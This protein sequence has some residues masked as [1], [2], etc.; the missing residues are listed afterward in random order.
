MR[1]CPDWLAEALWHIDCDACCVLSRW[2]V[3]TGSELVAQHASSAACVLLALLQTQAES[4][5]GLAE[6]PGLK[7]RVSS[8]QQQLEHAH[9]D[10]AA[11]QQAAAAAEQQLQDARV[12]LEQANKVCMWLGHCV[13]AGERRERQAYAMCVSAACVA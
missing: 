9:E 4:R 7:A 3:P 6:L 5:A 1:G 12:R 11:A 8:L 10:A 13:A 2:C